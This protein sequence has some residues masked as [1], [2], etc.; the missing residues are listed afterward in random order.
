M[1]FIYDESRT[2]LINLAHIATIQL[3][4]PE[5]AQKD[6]KVFCTTAGFGSYV[7]CSGNLAKCEA[8]LSDFHYK[9]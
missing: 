3:V 2:T 6:Y 7:L 5:L 9:H 1:E 4:K 8:F